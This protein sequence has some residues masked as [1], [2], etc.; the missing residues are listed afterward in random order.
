MKRLRHPPCECKAMQSSTKVNKK[1]GC[2][3]LAWPRPPSTAHTIRRKLPTPGC[4]IGRKKEEWKVRPTLVLHGGCPRT[5]S[6]PTYSKC[7]RGRQYPH[8]LDAERLLG[9]KAGKM[10]YYSIT[11]CKQTTRSECP[12]SQCR[13][14][15]HHRKTTRTQAE[16]TGLRTRYFSESPQ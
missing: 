2:I 15:S 9:T 11:V 4:S 13:Q 1:V 10:P 5:F 8:T 14:S 16:G 7:W 3:Y 12:I 6:C